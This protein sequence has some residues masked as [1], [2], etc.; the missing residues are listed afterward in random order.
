MPLVAGDGFAPDER[1]DLLRT[2][3]K[4]VTES[5]IRHEEKTTLIKKLRSR[6]ITK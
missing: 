1:V 3:E 6:G 5:R 4:N 2:I